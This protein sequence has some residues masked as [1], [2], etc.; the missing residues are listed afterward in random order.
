[1]LF[2]FCVDERGKH[3]K[4]KHI[5]D[6]RFVRFD[7]LGEDYSVEDIKKRVYAQTEPKYK[8][9]PKQD[10]VDDIFEGDEPV[11]IMTY[12]P[13]YAAYQRAI[14]SAEERP[15]YNIRMYYLVRRDVSH[16]RLY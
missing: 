14:K 7:S 1:M 13:L 15:I 3:A 16:M 4:I 6:K 9:F 10:S 11:A 12:V 2:C 5:G 8:G